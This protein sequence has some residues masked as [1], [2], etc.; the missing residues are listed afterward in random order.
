MKAVAQIVFVVLTIDV[1]VRLLLKLRLHMC[2]HTN[3][4]VYVFMF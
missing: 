4:R 2:M 1:H 3:N